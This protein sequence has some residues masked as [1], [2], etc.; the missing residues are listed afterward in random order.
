MRS[1]EEIRAIIKDVKITLQ[2]L[3]TAY[4][5]KELSREL[6]KSMTA[7]NEGILKT[8]RWVLREVE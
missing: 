2:N 7:E 1:E 8:L 4:N 6:F 3:I 5:D